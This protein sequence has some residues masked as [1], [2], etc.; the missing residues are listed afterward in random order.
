ML[1]DMP[2]QRI[3]QGLLPNYSGLLQIMTI[4][5]SLAVHALN[6]MK[7]RSDYFKGNIVL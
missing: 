4:D 3:A 2:L 6:A 1:K 7:R 5:R